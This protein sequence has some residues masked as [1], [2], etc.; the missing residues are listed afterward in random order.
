MTDAI[1]MFL[2]E[3]ILDIEAEI[4]NQYSYW[5]SLLGHTNRLAVTSQHLIVIHWE[6]EV[7]SYTALLFVR[8]LATVQASI[9]VH[10]ARLIA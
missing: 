8:N 7:E 6:N 3:S 2:A 1:D 10:E 5:R 4:R 9:L